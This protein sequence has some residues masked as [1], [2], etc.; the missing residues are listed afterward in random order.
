MRL[1]GRQVMLF[2]DIATDVKAFA[3]ASSCS[4]NSRLNLEETSDKDTPITGI[5]EMVGQEWSAET[6]NG[7][8]NL[9]DIDTLMAK[10]LAGE[11]ITLYL[12]EV[13]NYTREGVDK[14]TGKKWKPQPT[15]YSGKCVI[16][17]LSI[18]APADGKAEYTARFKGT[19]PLSKVTNIPQ[20]V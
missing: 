8:V 20:G 10:H 6:S 19:S 13:S 2:S 15:G 9:S 18:S 5:S 17:E 7:M 11:E 12:A 4:V 1:K 14:A 16:E 3:C